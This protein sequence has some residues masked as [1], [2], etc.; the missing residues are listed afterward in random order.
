MRH[1]SAWSRAGLAAALLLAA[2]PSVARPDAGA[3]ALELGVPV[4]RT[5]GGTRADVYGIA[6]GADQ[7]VRVRVER[8]RIA[9]MLTLTGPDG[10]E[11]MTLDEPAANERAE[12]TLTTGQSGVHLLTL[13]PHQEDAPPGSYSIEVTERRAAGPRDREAY[14]AE[15]AEARASVLLTGDDADT[16]RVAMAE[17][18]SAVDR[19]RSVGDDARLAT[20][21]ET[22]G[23]FRSQTGDREAAR[24]LW[25]EATAVAVRTGDRVRQAMIAANLGYHLA[26][27]GDA[28]RGRELLRGAVPVLRA[29]GDARREATAAS[30]LSLVDDLLRDHQS[31]L[32]GARRALEVARAAG[33]RDVEAGLLM[34]IGRCYLSLGH[35]RRALEHLQQAVPLLQAT[36]QNRLTAS[37][38]LMI[39]GVYNQLRDGARALPYLEDALQR[40]RRAGSLG[41]ETSI[42]NQLG[43]ARML[44]GEADE[45]VNTFVEAAALAYD[46]GDPR[47]Q[48]S[49]LR[50]LADA[51]FARG[52][53]EQAAGL[54]EESL[55]FARAIGDPRFEALGLLGLAR[56]AERRGRLVEADALI[57][58]SLRLMETARAQPAEPSARA[59]FFASGREAYE[60]AARIAVRRHQ[61][62]PDEG[63]DEDAF[64]LSERARARVLLDR[65][66]QPPPGPAG[67]RERELETEAAS[68]RRAVETEARK[69]SAAPEAGG[70]ASA[71]LRRLLSEEQV[72]WAEIERQRRAGTDEGPPEPLDLPRVRGLLDGETVLLEYLLGTEASYVF[73]VSREGLAVAELPGRAWLEARAR[74]L[75]E[76]L[77]A[78]RIFLPDEDD[79]DRERRLA[80]ADADGARTARELGAALLGPVAAQL[81][82]RSVLVVPDGALNYVPFAALPE[83]GAASDASL[84]V[85]RHDVVHL[86]SASV[87]SALRAKAGARIAPPKTLLVLADPV[88]EP[89]DPRV[90]RHAMRGG[91]TP[92]ALASRTGPSLRSLENADLLASID[93]AS[94]Q[95]GLGRLPFTR[96]EAQAIVALLP[97]ASARAA[98]GFDAT[99]EAALSPAMAD[100]RF[101]H[102][103]T[104]GHLDGD[105]PRLSA[106]VLSLV[107]A[108]GGA[109]DGFLRL[110]DVERMKLNADL[111]TLS[112]CETALGEEIDGEGL[113]GLTRA[114]L[115]AGARRVLATLWRVDDDATAS[116][117]ALFYRGILKDRLKPSEALAAAQR[118][119]RTHPRWSAPFY[120]AG[121]SLQGEPD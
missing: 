11:R 72:L 56:A 110:A 99:R 117:M 3:S 64:A 106:L 89:T 51:E 36:R 35:A 91:R 39:G 20:A 28:A 43:R 95:A 52:A 80:G 90:R 86:P 118:T 55:E 29:A 76:A 87:L 84:L 30:L 98:L 63:H 115:E 97:P 47:Q 34:R 92:A 78:R 121:A 49:V 60:L 62:R 105:D 73:A 21:L 119:M 38:V 109:Q 4:T 37:A 66:A 82:R 27:D 5:I 2:L 94:G 75:H 48:A 31:S 23:L 42:L 101:V 111:V 65:L 33:E 113:V 85:D 59:A 53:P 100:Y 81:G 57:Q 104:H 15:V 107:D 83:P 16:L 8:R 45:A 61:E 40:S 9:L 67:A 120:W 103:A 18:E 7:M 102:F 96:Q 44:Q 10:A 88:F 79:A 17:M 50:A 69:T 114:F 32:D 93:R 6:I 112:A 26:D 71:A 108:S 19:W 54:Y 12:M 1:A 77:A 14:L 13:R 74:R 41:V 22:L 70:G 25:E 68:L 58:G 46:R 24:A 116:L